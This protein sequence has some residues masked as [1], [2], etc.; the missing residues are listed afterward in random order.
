MVAKSFITKFLSP[1]TTTLCGVMCEFFIFYLLTIDI[2]G[3][4]NGILHTL[5]EKK[6][7][8]MKKNGIYIA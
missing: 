6:S 3:L 4:N 2:Y 8:K 5:S 7:A 1:I